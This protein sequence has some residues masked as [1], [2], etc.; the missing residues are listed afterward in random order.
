[1]SHLIDNSKGTAAFVSFQEPAWHG[2][3]SVVINAISA[4][5]ALRQGGLDFKVKKLPNIHRLENGAEMISTKSFFT[6]RTDVNKV[7]GAN[8]GKGYT[9][10]QNHEAL[11]IVDEILQSGTATIETAGALYNGSTVFICMKI[12]KDVI[13]NGSDITKQYVLIV[14]SH[15]GSKPAMVLFTNVRVVCHNTLTCAL[16]EATNQIRIRHTTNVTDRFREAAKILKLI[17]E[18]SDR[19]EEDY[20]VMAN[21]IISKE[22]M[23]DYFGNIFLDAPAIAQLQAGKKSKEVIGSMKRNILNAVTDYTIHGPGQVQTLVN[24][25]LTMW[26]AYNG[27]TG[28][29]TRK[30]FSTVDDRAESLLFGTSANL[31]QEAGVMALNPSRIQPLYSKKFNDIN[32]N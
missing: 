13:V 1:M 25:N 21:L 12:N 19:N 10:M 29:V 7:L 18:N 32:L 17:K 26:T 11:N 9:V 14:T 23:Y 27:V 4:E 3:G 6:Y 2:L 24:N 31:I 28:Y 20:N 30:K 5:D 16:G 22:Q 15:D 8:L